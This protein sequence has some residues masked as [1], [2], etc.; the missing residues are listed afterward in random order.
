[1]RKLVKSWYLLVLLL[2]APAILFAT[3]TF[4]RYTVSDTEIYELLSDGSLQ[5]AGELS[6]VDASISDDLSVAGTLTISGDDLQWGSATVAGSTATTSG[7]SQG[8]LRTAY[9]SGDTAAVEG[10]LLIATTAVAGQGV[11]VAVSLASNDQTNWVGTAAAATSTG[12]VVNYY[13]D[14][15]V[16]ARTTG[17]VVA[18]DVLVSSAGARGYLGVDVTPTTGADVGV[19]L[20]G[21]VA[22]GG[23][24]KIQLR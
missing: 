2:G 24:V 18:G 7:T 22:A 20:G 11:S 3:Y 16:L 9:L 19:A 5:L 10:S 23:L 6:A 12:S 8:D 1:M 4:Q 17:T 13:S 14:G 21:G 15:W